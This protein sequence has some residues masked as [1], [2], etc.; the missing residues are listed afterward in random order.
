M[1]IKIEKAQNEDAGRL[2]EV[3]NQSFYSDYVTYGECPGYNKT[4]AGMRQSI[5]KNM[6]YKVTA[7]EEI[8]GAISVRRE[9]GHRYYLGALCIIP[10]Y[11]NKGIGQTAMKYLDTE[12]PDARHWSL[13]TPADKLPNHYFYQKFGYR[14][15]KEYKDGSVAISYFERQL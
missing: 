14:I 1:H 2:A 5:S 3:F 10:A 11:A 7:D 12:F 15:T 9:S 6:V 13:E 8:V 4:E